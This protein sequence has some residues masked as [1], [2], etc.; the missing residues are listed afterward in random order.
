MTIELRLLVLLWL[1]EKR[2]RSFAE[3]DG[4]RRSLLVDAVN[5]V[6]R[7]AGIA[8]MAGQDQ[9]AAEAV[10]DQALRRL[11]INALYR[12]RRKRDRAGEFHVVRRNS[13]Q[14]HGRN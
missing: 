13:R 1:R 4:N 11:E 6:A 5:D 14:Q 2:P 3:L 8:C 7:D 9:K 10:M 12:V